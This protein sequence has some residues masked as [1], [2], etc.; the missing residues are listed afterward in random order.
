MCPLKYPATITQR[1]REITPSSDKTLGSG[2]FTYTNN[3]QP[4][5]HSQATTRGL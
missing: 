1:V 4:N 3:H 5:L 2:L